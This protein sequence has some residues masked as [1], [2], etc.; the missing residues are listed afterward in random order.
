ME[1]TQK[2]E[3]DY[4]LDVLRAIAAIYII[5]FWHHVDYVDLDLLKTPFTKSWAIIA[6]GVF[7]TVSAYLLTSQQRKNISSNLEGKER[8][9]IIH[10]FYI[11]RV[12]RIY[13]LYA[14]AVLLFFLVDIGRWSIPH[15]ITSLTLVAAVID[16]SPLTLWFINVIFIY[17]LAL[18]FFWF[19][20]RTNK[21]IV[22]SASALFVLLFVMH[23]VTPLI[24]ERIYVYLPSMIFGIFLAQLDT[25]KEFCRSQR[26]FI[27]SFVALILSFF[28][29]Q[30]DYL[31]VENI[32]VVLP[33]LA[34]PVL[35]FLSHQ[36]ASFEKLHLMWKS[37]GYASFAAYLFHRVLYV[38]LYQI[39][40]IE[41]LSHFQLVA[42]MSVI[43]IA[44]I[45]I[46]YGTQRCYDLCMRHFQ[47]KKS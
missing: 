14:A 46:S 39:F 15:L 33:I 22:F 21:K 3:R 24:D 16:K 13:P 47:N 8:T 35:M 32:S 30:V 1:N 43:T 17:Y 38:F 23:R 40:D 27:C 25:L 4:A 44:V 7:F 11:K 12:L 9:E 29:I 28:L 37:I 36:V 6:L 31:T 19:H 10:Q 26:A 42:L 20:M 18:P 5:G 41:D 34:F 2:P 45:V